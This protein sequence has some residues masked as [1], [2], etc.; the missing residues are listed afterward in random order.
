[1]THPIDWRALSVAS[2]RENAAILWMTVL[3]FLLAVALLAAWNLPP[4]RIGSMIVNAMLFASGAVVVA[5][6]A[7][8]IGLA[9]RRPDSPVRWTAKKWRDL[10]LAE[11]A[12]LA[13]PALLALIVFLPTFSAMKSA[14]PVFH[15]YAFDPL[16]ADID[17]TIHGGDVWRLLQPAIGHPFVSFLLNDVYHLWILLLYIGVLA[18]AGWIEEPAIRKQFFMTYFLAWPLLGNLMATWLSSVGPCFY[19]YF[20]HD[21][22][23][24]PQMAYL[25]QANQAWPLMVLEVQQELLQWHRA[26]SGELGRGISAMPSMHVSIA[27]LFTLVSWRISRFWGLVA[28]LFLA[29][30]LIGSVHLGYHYAIDGYAGIAGILLLWWLVGLILRRLGQL[31]ARTATD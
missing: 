22:R 27:F 5:G 7:V 21:A 6:P 1:M 29:L 8:L 31:R 10:R 17:R 20:Y 15:P 19:E 18:I 4:P 25:R 23:F 11:R 24:E 28:I 12:I 16:L 2:F 9:V 13:G 30:I 14:I 26:G 3:Y